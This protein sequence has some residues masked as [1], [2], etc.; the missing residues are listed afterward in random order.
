MCNKQNID[1]LSIASW[2]INGLYDKV[3][4]DLFLNEICKHDLLFITETHLKNEEHINVTGYYTLHRNH[5]QIKSNGKI[6]G[7]IAMLCKDNLQKGITIV[8]DQNP[9]YI[10]FKLDRQFFTLDKHLYVCAAYLPHEQS[11]YLAQRDQD[12]V[13]SIESDIAN[14]SRDGHILILGDLN[15]RS[16]VL[17][18]YVNADCDLN[19]YDDADMYLVDDNVGSRCNQDQVINDRGTKLVDLCVQCRLR[20]LNGRTLGD[21]QG[22]FTCHRP[23]GSSTVDYMVL[24]EEML[25]RV[26]FFLVHDKLD[27]S[28]HCKISMQMMCRV[29]K[30]DT[31]GKVKLLPMPP[32]YKWDD[33]S[34]GKYQA[35]LA[36]IE[37]N[38]QLTDLLGHIYA[39]DEHGINQETTLL[40]DIIHKAASKSL[41]AKKPQTNKDTKN[42]PWY[43]PSLRILRQR[44]NT[45]GGL[46]TRFPNDPYITGS[47]YKLLKEY[48]RAVRH[49]KRQFKQDMI[50]KLDEL[51][52]K[53]PQ[54]YWKLLNRL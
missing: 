52:D 50:N 33:C 7:G 8:N 26:Q 5:H 27:L 18:D 20:I 6:D 51:C 2:N 16:G 46:L 13:E 47:Y 41:R 44:I 35:A 38:N 24:S 29:R 14:L 39:L 53:S 32:S 48:R 43:H 12:T 31:R 1:F 25:H 10:W 17:N 22:Y 49:H 23:Q 34:I 28:D 21:S 11:H 54:E 40:N 36:D 3:H 9:D 45:K 30:P 37:I 42:Q 4:D 15:A 19:V